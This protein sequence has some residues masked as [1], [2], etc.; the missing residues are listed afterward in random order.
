M[1]LAALLVRSFRHFGRYSSIAC[2]FDADA[3]RRST[4]HD[5]IS[6]V[7]PDRRASQIGRVPLCPEY[8][9]GTV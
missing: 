1:G 4:Q 3:D 5:A 7:S 6:P 2:G 9:P 8:V